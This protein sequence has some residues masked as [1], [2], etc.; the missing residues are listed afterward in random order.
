[1]TTAV[2]RKYCVPLLD[3]TEMVP[4]WVQT[5]SEF[6][7]VVVCMVPLKDCTSGISRLICVGYTPLSKKN[8]SESSDSRSDDEDFS[9]L[10]DRGGID[11][12][13]FG[14]RLYRS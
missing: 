1:M 8:E 3:E 11:R 13:A 14:P 4:W 9:C 6:V 10:S 2:V 7:A 5:A 12:F